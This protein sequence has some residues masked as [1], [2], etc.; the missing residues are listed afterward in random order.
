MN[1]ILVK[2]NKP[3]K[4]N[5]EYVENRYVKELYKK[6]YRYKYID[7]YELKYVKNHY[8]LSIVF[9]YNDIIIYRFDNSDLY[10]TITLERI[11]KIKTYYRS[12]QWSLIITLL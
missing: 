2:K 1:V 11:D 10:D 12:L 5:R 6:Q 9:S 8:V 4:T 3:R 7:S